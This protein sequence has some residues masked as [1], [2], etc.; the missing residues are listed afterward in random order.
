MGNEAT[1]SLTIKEIKPLISALGKLH[2]ANIML[3][4]DGY[5]FGKFVKELNQVLRDSD[6][7][8][9]KLFDAFSVIL[10]DMQAS[11]PK[12]PA[13][14]EETE[15]I[16]AAKVA[17][18]EKVKQV[19]D[20]LNVKVAELE[21]DNHEFILKNGLFTID[22]ER[23]NVVVRDS[24]REVMTDKSTGTPIVESTLSPVEINVLEEK[25]VVWKGI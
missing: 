24:N 19:Q 3:G 13:D 4:K 23:L 1:V 20:D 25:L 5:W 17:F 14:G 16:K 9:K 11:I 21:D 18:N 8:R 10:Q 6:T 15:E 22:I 2:N 7:E 12:V